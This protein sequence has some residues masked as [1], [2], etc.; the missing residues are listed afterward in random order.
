MSRRIEDLDPDVQI[1]CRDLIAMAAIRKVMLGVTQTYRTFPEQAAI[2]ARGRTAPGVIVTD[3][4]PGWSW[5]NWKRAFDVDI[6]S[7]PGDLTPINLYDGPWSFVGALGELIGLEWGGRWKHGD[8]PH[9][10]LIA[11]R[12]LAQLRQQYPQGLS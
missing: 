4:P 2:Y 1:L 10:Q 11:G 8:R 9:F 3:A 6:L 7:F 5:H 12:S